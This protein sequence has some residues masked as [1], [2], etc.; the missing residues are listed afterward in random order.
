LVSI[1]IESVDLAA[2]SEETLRAL[3][4]LYDVLDAEDLP[5]DP[6]EPIEHR[7]LDLRRTFARFPTHRW[8][9]TDNG[10][11]VAA[12]VTHYDVEEN[13]ENG[14]G[15][16]AVHPSYRGRGHARRLAAP[17]LDHLSAAGRTRVETW[18]T[19]GHPAETLA[20][21]LGL[22]RALSERRSR[23]LIADLD[24]AMMSE[25]VD[26]ASQRAG[27]YELQAMTSPFPEEHLEQFCEMMTVMNT[28]PLEDYVMDDEHITA[29]DWRDIES[30]VMA[31]RCQ[32]NNLTAVHRPSGAFVGYTQVKTQDLQPD[33][34]WQWDT[35][36]HPDH[37]N[38]GL[39]RWLK[40]DMILRIIGDYP[41][42]C[43]IDTENAASNQP[44][45]NINL[46]MGFKPIHDTFI[47]Q[48]ELTTVRERLGV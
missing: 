17:I 43:R 22:K 24:V 20:E 4:A 1:E 30:E 41:D 19:N 47:W 35:G 10:Q 40:A 42:V 26:R 44:M 36:V 14:F 31:S 3:A 38:K 2:A 13:L 18:I 5:D 28:A 16:I 29:G 12:A 9:L 23:L 15:R 37:R 46:A 32:I 11:V 34:A 25:W 8:A 21:N 39:G 48:G 6:P 7:M 45:L 33:L 27:D